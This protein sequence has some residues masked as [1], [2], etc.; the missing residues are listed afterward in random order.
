MPCFWAAYR[1]YVFTAGIPFSKEFLH[2][3]RIKDPYTSQTCPSVRDSYTWWSSALCLVSI[4]F[5]SE[6]RLWQWAKSPA[7][8]FISPNK[9]MPGFCQEESGFRSNFPFQVPGWSRL[10]KLMR[11]TLQEAQMGLKL[12]LSGQVLPCPPASKQTALWGA[13][14]TSK[15][16]CH[17]AGLPD[18]EVFTLAE[19]DYIPC[20]P[21]QGLTA[22]GSFCGRAICGCYAFLPAPIIQKGQ[23]KLRKYEDP[24]RNRRSPKCAEAAGCTT[25]VMKPLLNLL[26]EV[27]TSSSW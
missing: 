18:E 19:N 5:C 15:A 7:D 6:K 11:I 17:S 3:S 2:L 27:V 8:Y 10:P 9:G 16:A 24:D 14:S 20:V 21:S 22:V 26:P 25:E 4:H 1:C 12:P 23:R 13:M